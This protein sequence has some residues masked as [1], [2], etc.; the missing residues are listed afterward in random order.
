MTGPT[1]L[2]KGAKVGTST[3]LYYG[4]G[5]AVDA[6]VQA[7]SVELLFPIERANSYTAPSVRPVIFAV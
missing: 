6:I 3:K 1:D 7:N 4:S 5:Q 2:P